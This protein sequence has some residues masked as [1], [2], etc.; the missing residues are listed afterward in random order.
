MQTHQRVWKIFQQYSVV[1][2]V[3]R[4][5]LV[6]AFGLCF[7]GMDMAGFA[8][9]THAQPAS[10]C[11]NHDNTYFVVRGDTLQRIAHRYGINW[12]A[13]ASYNRIANPNLI[14]TRQRICIPHQTAGSSGGRVSSYASTHAAGARLKSSAIPQPSAESKGAVGTGNFFPYGACT[15]WANQRYHQ[16]HNVFV[17]WTTN[18]NAWQ[19]V[20]RAYQFGWHV[21]NT[22]VKGSI[23][24]L[25]PWV[26]GAY[27]L[28]HVAYVESVMSNGDVLASS[29]SWGGHPLSVTTFQFHP[30]PGVS[31]VSQ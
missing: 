12:H 17:P 11:S 29:M 31:F 15:W 22:P 26:Q 16:V 2:F 3:V 5:C 9:L 24:V 21:S 14:Y 28:G 7:T 25:Q 4:I 1:R 13:L 23:I 8:A 10:M 19:W 30:G 6:S 18:A 27:G 20:A